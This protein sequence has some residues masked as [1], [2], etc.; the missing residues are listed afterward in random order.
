MLFDGNNLANSQKKSNLRVVVAEVV[1]EV[2]AV[3]VAGTD[4][5][6]VQHTV[7]VAVLLPIYWYS[8][9]S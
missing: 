4:A 7:A 9:M 1:A 2:S 3:V 5:P 8:S 6:K